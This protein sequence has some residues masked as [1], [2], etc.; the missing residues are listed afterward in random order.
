MAGRD[1]QRAKQMACPHVR[2]SAKP[3]TPVLALRDA[4]V[5]PVAAR[6][7]R[8]SARCRG[9]LGPGE[10]CQVAPVSD[11]DLAAGGLFEHRGPNVLHGRQVDPIPEA[12]IY[13]VTAEERWCRVQACH[14]CVCG[15]TK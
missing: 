14:V 4:D 11:T 6:R 1:R 12:E 2:S 10:P 3:G 7:M 15:T 5:Q 8:G 9:V 13:V